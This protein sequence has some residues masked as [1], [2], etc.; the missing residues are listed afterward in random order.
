MSNYTELL[1]AEN[2]TL[3]YTSKTFAKENLHLPG[4]DFVRA[5]LQPHGSTESGVTQSTGAMGRRSSRRER[6]R[7]DSSCR[8]RH[9]TYRRRIVWT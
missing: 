9:R 2:K 6:V 4:G 1:G 8:P 5:N 3:G 7:V